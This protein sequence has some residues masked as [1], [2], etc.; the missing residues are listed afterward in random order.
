MSNVC[1]IGLVYTQVKKVDTSDL[2]ENQKGTGR[3]GLH[4]S[5]KGRSM[6]NIH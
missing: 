6:T 2:H 5:Q 1:H 4:L 3:P